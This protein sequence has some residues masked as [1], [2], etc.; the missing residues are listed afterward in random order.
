MCESFV[1][2]T[3]LSKVIKA[4]LQMHWVCHIMYKG[5]F[6]FAVSTYLYVCFILNHISSV[7]CVMIVPRFKRVRVVC[8]FIES[9][10]SMLS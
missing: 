6:V 5:F 8:L 2:E 9:V 3:C 10:F 7:R 1:V 4:H